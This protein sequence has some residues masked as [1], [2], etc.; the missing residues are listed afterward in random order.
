MT[1]AGPPGSDPGKTSTTDSATGN[2]LLDI[3]PAEVRERLLD[4]AAVQELPLRTVLSLADE[5]VKYVYFLTAGLASLVY[6]S[7][8]GNSVELATI[9]TEGLVGWLSALGGMLPASESRMQMRGAGYRVPLL[10]LQREF[11]RSPAVRGRVLE[12]AQQQTMSAHQLVACNRLHQAGARFAR[13]LLMVSDRV[14]AGELP[15]TQEFL[16]NMLGTRRTTVAEEAG[17]LQ[18][19]GA[20]DYSRGVV[21]IVNRAVL[22]QRA[23]ECYGILKK[24]FDQ[25]YRTPIMQG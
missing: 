10:N 9:G 23:C 19:A 7:E 25:L 11:E 1:A 8:R 15:M 3:L 18:R 20:I 22:E 6:T 21:R 14:G 16:A 24:Q 12:F 17:A 13:W 2:Q 5:P 4:G